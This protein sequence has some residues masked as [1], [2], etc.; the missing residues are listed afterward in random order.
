MGARAG[1]AV[2]FGLLAGTAMAVG[3]EL[4]RAAPGEVGLSPERLDKITSAL[5]EDVAQKRLVG[6]VLLIARHGKIAYLQAV[7]ARDAQENAPMTTDSIFRIYSMSKVITVDA[8]LTLV[9][10]G[11]VAFDDPIAKYL[12]QFAN[13][14][15]GAAVPNPAGGDSNVMQL[16]PA[17]RPITVLDLMR[18]SSGITYG[19]FG[20]TLV[21]KAYQGVDLLSG[22]FTNADLVDRLAKL[23][24]SYQPGTTWDY[25]Y[26]I[27]V[28][29]R[30]VEVVSGKSLYQYEKERLLDPLQMPDTSFYVTD[31]AKKSRIA[32]PF[33]DDKAMGVDLTMSDPTDVR[34]W[35]SGGGGMVSTAMDYARLLQ[36]MLDGG[37]LDGKRYLAPETIAY[38]T[39][40]QMGTEV[41]PGPYYLPGPG[42][43]F[44][45]GVAVRTSR[46]G[47]P[48]VGVPG[49][50]YW[51][52]AG[53][54]YFWVD[55]ANDMFVVFMMQ[56]P[57]QRL[58][59]R[60]VL[61]NMVYAA[62]EK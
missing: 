2:F 17:R 57:K 9:E 44:G 42:Y 3:A 22:K 46:G 41:H 30:L 6:G 52:G 8:A 16:V 60:S 47:S 25:S 4:P 20:D 59:Y 35:E 61:R 21:K 56:S 28:L 55:P 54:T 58:H 39:A 43:G 38:M 11:L 45:L 23:P 18:H 37:R 12:P 34:P 14:N 27:D 15:V 31:P 32:Q 62:V 13:M 24:L 1:L 19:F 33:P 5:K 29:G 50:W 26:S 10:D 40:D 49:D 51:G 48:A 36:M 7:G 53:G